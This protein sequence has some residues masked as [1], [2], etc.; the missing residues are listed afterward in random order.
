M[1][2][3]TGGAG[4][5]GSVL[6]GLLNMQGE[7]EILVV[8]SLGSSDKW[9][10]LVGKEFCDYL[11][12]DDFLTLLTEGSL[13]KEVTTIIHLGAC[14]STL[15]TDLDYLTENNYR[16]SRALAEWALAHN[17]RFIYASSGAT[18]GD[19][20]EGF[21]DDDALTPHLRPLNGYAF[22]KQLFDLWL[23]REGLQSRVV[24]LKFFN[25]YGPNEYHKDEMRSVVLKAFEQI[26]S[27]GLVRLFRSH[28]PNYADGG[29]L[30]DFIYVKDVAN[31][32][33]WFVA[34]PEHNGIFNV[35]T[36]RARSWMD[37]TLAVFKALGKEA[38][39]SFIDMPEELQRNYQYFTEARM[40]K[41]RQI[42]FSAPFYS[43][44]EGVAD[45]VT[46]YLVGHSFY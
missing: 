3:V 23:L 44:E 36:G 28:N 40:E 9:K 27:K 41:L 38:K 43:L 18:Y 22:S 15:E 17:A 1:I 29:Q 14:T 32:L 5:I 2:V 39:I 20:T 30:R 21:S 25:V 34:H 13:S 26:Q 4:F 12:K 7:K 6:V 11:H 10:N 24:G 33:S 46:S 16:Y 35:G 19:G 45:Y 42:G 31:V 8:D 37:L